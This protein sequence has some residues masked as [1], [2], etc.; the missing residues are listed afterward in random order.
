MSIWLCGDVHGCMDSVIE[1]YTHAYECGRRP[2]AVIFLGDLECS[3]ALEHELSE[4]RCYVDDDVW[5]IPGNHD[6]DSNQSWNSLAASRWS[7]NNLHGK[8]KKV[9][10]WQ[11]AGLGGVFRS[12]IWAPPEKPKFDSYK[13]F[14]KDLI[15]RRPTREWGLSET[16]AE[17]RH[18]STIFP[19]SV[20]RLGK[21][22]AQ[23]LVTHEAPSC[24]PFGWSAIDGLAKRM[25]VSYVFHGHHHETKIYPYCD[26][27]AVGVGY[28][29]ILELD[30]DGV[31][32]VIRPG[33]YDLEGGLGEQGEDDYE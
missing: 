18:L 5:F 4:I 14:R 26:F 23:I 21:Q 11:V 8:V 16:T 22:R 10:G 2:K 19:D 9:G 29:A 15:S 32:S 20:Q 27:Q 31:I 13:E 17:R 6:T 33:D 7:D 25:G 24:H 30:G 1:A 3:Q 12:S 28:K